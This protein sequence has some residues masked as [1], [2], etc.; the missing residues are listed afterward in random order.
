MS[1]TKMGN[2]AFLGKKHSKESKK[3]MSDAQIAEKNNAWKGGRII[4]EGYILI[5]K[6]NHPYA[7]K[8][9][10]V[11]EHR[12]IMEKQLGRYLKPKE[13]VHHENKIT[14]ANY[15]EN[16]GLFESKG[17]HLAYHNHQNRIEEQLGIK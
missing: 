11:R 4:Q 10:Y 13:V 17:K 5:L 16:L 14:D 6:R 7:S 8:K 1:L 9:G 12:L 3:K 15:P 2:K